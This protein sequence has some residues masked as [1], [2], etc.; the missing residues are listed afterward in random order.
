MTDVFLF[1]LCYG[2]QIVRCRLIYEIVKPVGEKEI[3][4]SAPGDLRRFFGVV[5]GKIVFRDLY[6]LALLE[7]TEILA[8]KCVGIVLAVS[9]DKDL[10]ALFVRYGVYAG[11]VG[12]GK[13]L[14]SGGGLDI[15]TQNGGVARM[16]RHK[17]VVKAAEKDRALVVHLVRENTENL[18]VKLMLIYAVVVIKPRLC[19]PADMQGAVNVSLAPLHYLDELLPILDLLEGH[20]L[21]R[22]AGDDKAVVIIVLYVVEY[23]IKRQKMLLGD[24]LGLMAFGMYK[25][26]ESKSRGYENTP[27]KQARLQKESDYMLKKWADIFEYGDPYYNPNFSKKRM[28]YTIDSV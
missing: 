13:Y 2:A 19:A 3:C 23:L 7:V 11:L 18:F 16:R 5:V 9:C 28:D 26:N 15:L 6:R 25:L 20:M 4:V 17:L 12:R 24:V 10:S 27:E 14:K 21:N 1:S 8:L 22:C